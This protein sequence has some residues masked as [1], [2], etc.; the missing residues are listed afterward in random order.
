MSDETSISRA[1]V[2]VSVFVADDPSSDEPVHVATVRFP[3]VPRVGDDVTLSGPEF[4]DPERDEAGQTGFKVEFVTWEV[5]EDSDAT[6][7][8][9]LKADR[10]FSGPFALKCTCEKRTSKG[11]FESACDDCGMHIPRPW[12]ERLHALQVAIAAALS[13]P[14][15]DLLVSHRMYAPSDCPKDPLFPERGAWIAAQKFPNGVISHV[16]VDE[17]FKVAIP[18]VEWEPRDFEKQFVSALEAGLR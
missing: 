13:R 12:R 2:D 6:V 9:T 11:V 16:Y 15:A 8:I 7:T 4:G 3:A 18:G 1:G 14:F 17:H 5:D 10:W